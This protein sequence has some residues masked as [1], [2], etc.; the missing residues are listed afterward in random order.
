MDTAPSRD[1]TLGIRKIS[2]HKQ[3]EKFETVHTALENFFY[4]IY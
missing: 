4:F 2:N 3:I 1:Q